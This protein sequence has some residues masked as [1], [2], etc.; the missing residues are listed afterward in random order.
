M[1][2][3]LLWMTLLIVGGLTFGI[4]LSFVVFADKMRIAPILHIDVQVQPTMGHEGL[5]KVLEQAK[6]ERFNP[7]LRQF[8]MIDQI[9]AATEVDRHLSERF[10][11]RNGSPAEPANSLFCTEG[12]LQCFPEDDADIFNRMVVVNL[13][14]A[15]GLDRQIEESMLAQKLQHVV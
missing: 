7:P 12:L 9:R 4:R 2:Q 3:G 13:R 8:D 10:I 14:I 6:V 5:E 15:F 1:S 11:E